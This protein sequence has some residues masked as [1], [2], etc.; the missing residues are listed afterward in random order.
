MKPSKKKPKKGQLMFNY[1]IQESQETVWE[2]YKGKKVKIKAG[3]DKPSKI[4]KDK[5]SK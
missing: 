2:D 4:K 3:K 1:G 5:A